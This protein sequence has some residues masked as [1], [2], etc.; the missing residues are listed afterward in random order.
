MSSITSDSDC[1][2]LSGRGEDARAV[3]ARRGGVRVRTRAAQRR[4]AARHAGGRSRKCCHQ[5]QLHE[6]N[7]LFHSFN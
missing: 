1:E 5:P 4:L 7:G 6:G 2:V 3:V